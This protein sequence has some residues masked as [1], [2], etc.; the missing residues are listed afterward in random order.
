MRSTGVVVKNVTTW[1]WFLT[2]HDVTS[3]S[4]SSNRRH[5]SAQKEV[6]VECARNAVGSDNFRRT[7]VITDSRQHRVWIPSTVTRLGLY[8]CCVS[9]Y[10]KPKHWPDFRRITKN[11]NARQK[12]LHRYFSVGWT[13]RK[14][15]RSISGGRRL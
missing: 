3:V 1:E 12:W 5:L 13:P 4:T 14:D 9:V 10:S 7:E 6:S 11:W 2:R 8:V 15:Y